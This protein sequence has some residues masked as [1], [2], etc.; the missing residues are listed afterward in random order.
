MQELQAV[1]ERTQTCLD[2]AQQIAAHLSTA[3]LVTSCQEEYLRIQS[4]LAQRP[5]QR[6][7]SEATE[8]SF[9]GASKQVVEE[10]RGQGTV[11]YRDKFY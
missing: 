8:H 6:V 3:A 9:D 4:A 5:K 10:A 2:K 1:K 7:I 11:M